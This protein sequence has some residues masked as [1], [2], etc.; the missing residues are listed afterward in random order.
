MINDCIK[1]FKTDSRSIQ[2]YNCSDGV[3]LETFIPCYPSEY[4]KKVISASTNNSE[5]LNNLNKWWAGLPLYSYDRLDSSWRSRNPRN[6]TFNV[7]RELV[8]LL[9]SDKPWFPTVATELTS[10]LTLN[11]SLGRQFPIRIMHRHIQS[12]CCNCQQ[13]YCMMHKDCDDK[14]YEFGAKAKQLLI[15]Y[16]EKMEKEIYQLCNY[17]K[18]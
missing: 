14:L 13:F 16:V 6:N 3:K 7:S 1:T 5:S 10:I 8:A 9:S 12:F 2:C 15:D 17:C 11:C 4:V 18:I